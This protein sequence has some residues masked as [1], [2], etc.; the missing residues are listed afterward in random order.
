[1]VP[2]LRAVSR[3]VPQGLGADALRAVMSRGAGVTYPPV[4]NGIIFPTA[5]TFGHL[6]LCA[7]ARYVRY[8]SCGL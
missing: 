8:R 5:W 2:F 7:V 6:V 3:I 1:M 4:Y